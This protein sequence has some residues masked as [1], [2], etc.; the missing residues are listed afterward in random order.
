MQV[1]L[2]E[3]LL[4]MV[5]QAIQAG[6]APDAQSYVQG[7]IED[8]AAKRWMHAN[9]CEI[10]ALLIER[11]KQP[12]IKRDPDDFESLRRRVRAHQQKNPDSRSA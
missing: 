7:L 5:N 8:A 10:E 1:Q 11:M 2:D 9:Q 3:H 12:G 6:E 4:A